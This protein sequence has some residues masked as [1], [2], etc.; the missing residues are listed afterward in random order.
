LIL[1]FFRTILKYMRTLG[2]DIETIPQRTLLSRAQKVWLNNKISQAAARPTNESKEEVKRRIMGTSPYLGE[3]VCIGMG[4]ITSQGKVNTKSLTG[5]EDEILR[6]FWSMLAN[7]QHST[8]VS[9]NGLKFDVNFILMR[10]LKHGIRPTNQEFTNTKKFSKYPHFDVM[11]WMS[12]W[13]Y[14][15]PGLDIACDLAGI[16]SSKEGAV[17]AKDV[18]QAF[19]DGRISEIA[20]YC[21]ED[22]RATLELYIKLRP[23]IRD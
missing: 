17:K 21:E 1:S 11:Q 6:K 9:F 18:A 19:E 14:P 10:S 8:Y 23:Y 5:K 16:A 20:E 2:F 15:V 22:V 13:G 3:I 4:E 7:V 12:D